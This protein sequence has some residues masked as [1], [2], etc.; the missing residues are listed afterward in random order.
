V[1]LEGLD[2]RRLRGDLVVE[3][4]E[5]VGDPFLLKGGGTQKRYFSKLLPLIE[6]MV[7]PRSAATCF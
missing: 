4:G 6:L 1:L 5:A 3:G 7:A 2:L